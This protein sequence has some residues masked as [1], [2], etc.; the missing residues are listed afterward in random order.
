MSTRVNC[1]EPR[2]FS[3][4]NFQK[5]VYLNVLSPIDCNSPRYHVPLN[6]GDRKNVGWWWCCA[7]GP[8][9]L[10]VRLDRNAYMPEETIAIYVDFNS[11]RDMKVEAMLFQRI[12]YLYDIVTKLPKCSIK[13]LIE[14]GQKSDLWSPKLFKLPTIESTNVNCEILKVE[15]ALVISMTTRW[16]D[17]LIAS[18]PIVI[19]THPYIEPPPTE[20][21]KSARLP[22]HVNAVPN[23]SMRTDPRP[24]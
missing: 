18:F 2:A 9:S 8:V 1:K 21:N 7:S 24:I 15:Y 19:G 13:Q 23:E 11:Q 12:S 3:S 14:T 22:V 4:F 16:I 20:F 5:T 10:D 17:P 6:H